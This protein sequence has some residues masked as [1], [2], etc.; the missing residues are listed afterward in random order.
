MEEALATIEQ[1]APVRA[2]K[3]SFY[4][5][6]LVNALHIMAIG[7]LWTSVAL[8]D[9]RVLG[10]LRSLDATAFQAA[11]RRVALI[12]FAVALASGV[13]LFS[14]RA[15][16]YAGSGV[17]LAKMGLIVLAGLNLLVFDRLS[18]RSAAPRQLAPLA[19][20]SLL[21]WTAVLVCG[22]FIGFL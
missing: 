14:V 1:L 7:A 2:L 3:A 5:Y 4:A 11:F 10:G 9:L 19:V 6:P 20:V 12:A 15:G 17:F 8:M 16:H 21:L 22:R 18:R 13:A